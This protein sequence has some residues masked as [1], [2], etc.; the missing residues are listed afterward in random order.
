MFKS[1]FTKYITTFMLIIIASFVMLA[2]IISSMM[3][4]YYTDSSDQQIASAADS[5]RYL[6]EERLADFP[7]ETLNEYIR[8]HSEEV[9]AYFSALTKYSGD[10][11]LFVTDKDGK[12][13]ASVGFRDPA[14]GK[15]PLSSEV[16]EQIRGGK[17][18]T[19]GGDL[20]GW[21][22]NP[23]GAQTIWAHDGVL[24]FFRTF[25]GRSR[26]S[27]R[28]RPTPFAAAPFTAFEVRM[29]LRRQTPQAVR[30]CRLRLGERR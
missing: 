17:S 11:A 10:V 30:R 28:S 16:M 4:S 26:A 21:Y 8:I 22:R 9:S 20:Q 1:I 27:I 13:L 29:R 12:I 5:M 24:E 25:A 14:F 23:Y 7:S 3:V 2:S 18:Y 19:D 6:L 15:A